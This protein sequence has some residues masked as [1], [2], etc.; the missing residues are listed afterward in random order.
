MRAR[1]FQGPRL[2]VLR[3]PPRQG[4]A[5]DVGVCSPAEVCQSQGA[6]AAKRPLGVGR[7]VKT[8]TGEPV[9]PP[10]VTAHVRDLCR[11]SRARPPR[12][13]T[14]QRRIAG[15]F[16][17]PVPRSVRS[18]QEVASGRAVTGGGV[19]QG[20]LLGARCHADR[21]LGSSRRSSASASGS[22]SDVRGRRSGRSPGLPSSAS[23]PTLSHFT[24]R[25][26]TVESEARNVS[27]IR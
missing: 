18:R 27:S 1:R 9:G 10:V 21:R 23:A 16:F 20:R 8:R 4:N 15:E 13:G 7:Q 19:V 6:E 25:G 26:Q 3:A 24:G 14:G 2:A 22:R 5:R 12:A 11:G 17:G